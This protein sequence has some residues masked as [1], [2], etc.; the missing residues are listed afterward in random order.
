[1]SPDSHHAFRPRCQHARARGG[2]TLRKSCHRDAIR[3]LALFTTSIK[4][5]FCLGPLDVN[6][7]LR[8]PLVVMHASMS[9]RRSL[10]SGG[11]P[12]GDYYSTHVRMQGQTVYSPTDCTHLLH[13]STKSR[14]ITHSLS[15]PVHSTGM[16]R[17]REESD[18]KTTN[19]RTTN[20]D[21]ERYAQK[22]KKRKENSKRAKSEM[23]H[24]GMH[25]FTTVADVHGTSHFS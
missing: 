7:F 13:L 19:E 6:S 18:T 21:T 5:L 11:L 3:T 4:S 14:C 23:R 9:T 25:T 2:G 8:A 24:C 10:Y 15:S 20:W 1:M 17:C 22:Q 12:A 16:N